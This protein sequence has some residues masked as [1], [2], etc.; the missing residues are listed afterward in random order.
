MAKCIFFNLILINK[1]SCVA[2]FGNAICWTILGIYITLCSKEYSKI[3]SN[4]FVRIQTL[5]FGMFS[6]IF[7]LCKNLNFYLKFKFLP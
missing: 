1:A 5:F 6:A 2:G 4:T 3:T 7:C